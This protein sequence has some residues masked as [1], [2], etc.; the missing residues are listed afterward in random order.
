MSNLPGHIEDFKQR[1]YQS[2]YDK[3]LANAGKD[4]DIFRGGGRPGLVLIDNY[5]MDL[6]LK[7]IESESSY[8]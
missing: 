6:E 1:T 2:T 8:D 5:M 4:K 3:N 7:A